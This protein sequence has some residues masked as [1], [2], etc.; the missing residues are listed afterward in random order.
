MGLSNSGKSTVVA[1]L[2]K[3]PV[4]EVAPTVGFAVESVKMDGITM[5]MFDMSGKACVTPLHESSMSSEVTCGGHAYGVVHRGQW[6]WGLGLAHWGAPGETTTTSLLLHQA[7]WRRLLGQQKPL[8]GDTADGS[9]VGGPGYCVRPAVCS[10]Y[11]CVFA[12][13]DREYPVP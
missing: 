12:A 13:H 11:G 7:R 9:V 6:G 8:Q 10:C 5:T 3:D 4:E 1:R 2:T